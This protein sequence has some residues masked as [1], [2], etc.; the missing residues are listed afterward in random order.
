MNTFRH[1]GDRGDLIYFLPVI[2]HFGGGVL[3]IEA[4]PY[5]RERLTP[6]NWA[7]LDLLLKQQPYIVDVLPW[8]NERTAVCGNDFRA[9]MS[10]HLRVGQGKNKSLLH[11]MLD[12]HAVPHSAA[13]E[14]WLTVEPVEPR[15]AARVVFSRSGAGR[16]PQHHYHNPLFPWHYVWRK[17]RES[18]VF[19]GL[20]DEHEN[21]CATCGAVPHI[22]TANLLEAA[23]A[24]AGCELFV[25]N[26]NA[27]HAIA[28]AMK[29]RIVLEVW[30]Q[31]PN[32]LSFRD[33][34]LHGWDSS[35]KL[36]DL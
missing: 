33:G 9:H 10:R 19:V 24:I 22:K 36:P 5:T 7:G 14:P 35:L 26:Q 8:R 32:C 1:A 27:C 31:G 12:A 6:E 11:W 23:Q 21:F 18:A 15:P 17:Y 4:A 29:K 28:E 25:G 13:D 3:Y 2:R 30:P 20:P 16:A 34:V